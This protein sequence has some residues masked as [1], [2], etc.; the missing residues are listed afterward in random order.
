[1]LSE[2]VIAV[3]SDEKSRLGK[4]PEVSSPGSDT[5]CEEHFTPG[6]L[7]MQIQAMVN[8]YSRLEGNLW[9]QRV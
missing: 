1:M 7:D 9:V 6:S 2:T 5:L 3:C 8:K 4:D